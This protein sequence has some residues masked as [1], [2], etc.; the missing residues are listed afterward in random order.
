MQ[1]KPKNPTPNTQL[2]TF[3]SALVSRMNM[4]TQMGLTMY[5]GNR[6]INKALGYKDNLLFD[7]YLGRYLRQDIAKAIIDRP[8]NATWQ[9]NIELIETDDAQ[10]TP[11]EKE[12]RDLNWKFG[13][14]SILARVDKLTGIGR[15]GVLLLGLDDVSNQ[16]GFLKPVKPGKRTL[17]YLKPFSEKSA[18]VKEWEANPSNARYGMP[19]IYEIEVAD[20]ASGASQQVQVHYS[21][22]VH[23]IDNSLESEVYGTPRL[24]AVFNRLMDLEKV[25]GGS[26]EMF[27]RGAR[28][29]HQGVIDKDYTLTPEAETELQAQMDEYENGLRR[30]LIN[31]GVDL[32]SLET[33][34]ATPKDHV[35]VILTCISAQTG[36]PKRI[37]SGSERGELSSGQDSAEWKTYTKS[38]REDHAEPRIIRVFV[39][40]LIELKVLPKPSDEYAVDWEDLFAISE[41]DRVEIGKA[42]ANALREYTYNPLSAMIIPPDGFKEFFL[43]FTREQIELMKAMEEGDILEELE[44]I[45]D[46]TTPEKEEGASTEEKESTTES[47]G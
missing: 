42:R 7:D 9:G 14:K 6:D 31:E 34:V 2:R 29:G 11:F 3:A 22:I 24:E 33:Q 47:D 32:K 17:A 21:R 43:G 5:E 13:I 25:V 19:L 36:I 23:I 15:Y 40:R 16:A 10:E 45:R 44:A 1:R 27:W 8:V 38:R 28:P 35:D 18:K 46:A 26:A 39:D 30:L 4:A 12:W 41:K 20:V 37:L